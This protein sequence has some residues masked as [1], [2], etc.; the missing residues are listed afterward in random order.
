LR[1]VVVKSDL[2]TRYLSDGIGLVQP[3]ALLSSVVVASTND[4]YLR[5][6]Y[7][8]LQVPID[9]FIATHGSLVTVTQDTLP[10]EGI[11]MLSDECHRC[12]IRVSHV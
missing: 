3:S 1:G 5:D 9:E 6:A 4:T 12:V 8:Y 7:R 10:L 11:R 2:L